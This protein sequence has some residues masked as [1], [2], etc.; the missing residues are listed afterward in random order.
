MAT[1]YLLFNSFLGPFHTFFVRLV[2][3]FLW[4]LNEVP[5]SPAWEKTVFT[6][7]AADDTRIE[8]LPVILGTEEIIF[9]GVPPFPA[10]GAAITNVCFGEPDDT[11]TVF[12]PDAPAM[13]GLATLIIFV[14]KVLRIVV[15]TF[16]CTKP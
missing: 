4:K 6:P 8:G 14:G 9:A 12:V 13:D 1:F 7:L 5:L 3:E 16:C 15:I 2:T 10:P 11:D